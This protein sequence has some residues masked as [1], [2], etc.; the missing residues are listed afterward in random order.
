MSRTTYAEI[1]HKLVDVTAK[2]EVAYSTADKLAKTS[3]A[4]I[5][6]DVY[7]VGADALETLECNAWPLDGSKQIEPDDPATVTWGLWTNSVTSAAGAFA[8]PPAL[9]TTFASVHTS[10]GLTFFFSGDTWPSEMIITWYNG[11]T[12]LAQQ[13]YQPTGLVFYAERLVTNY[14]K[15]TIQFTGTKVPQRHLK[16]AEIDFG[17]V[18]I[19]GKTAP[20]LISAKV[21]E[22]VDLTSNELTIDTLDFSVHDEN[23]DFNMLNPGGVYVALQQNQELQ[24]TE[25][26]NGAPIAMGVYYLDTW[27]NESPTVAKFS[28]DSIMGVF[29]KVDYRT[30]PLWAGTAA[31][32]VFADIFAAA[33]FTNYTIDAALATEPVY[34][35]L[36]IVSVRAALQNVCLATR[37]TI[38][39]ARDGAVKVV[40]LPSTAAPQEIE[41]SQKLGQQKVKQTPVVNSVLVTSHAFAAGASTTLY[42]GTLTA[43]TYEVTFQTQATGIG[44]TGAT[45]VTAG[46][47]Y[48][49]V[50]VATTGTVTITGNE[51]KEYE[52]QHLYESPG[53]SATTR[54]QVKVEDCPLIAPQNAAAIAQ[55]LHE[56]Y[57]RRIVQSFKIQV[58]DEA[59]GDNLDVNTMLDARKTCIIT[60]MEIDLTGGFLADCEVRG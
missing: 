52:L 41:K 42:T 53:L 59:V 17:G 21:L 4:Q 6:D 54:S 40:R 33:G 22:E 16:I 11:A 43:G 35:C 29:D 18:V 7:T 34:G 12:Q 26:L 45:L 13:V 46:V 15:I 25:Y 60:K 19:W 23:S 32:V 1:R 47:N 50:T 31:S 58:V 55:Y 57:Q 56:D 30:G 36:D 44:V 49:K 38:I 20:K 9:Q 51:L 8:V 37:S 27:E 10:T 14:N 39:T 48:A 2:P 3:Y 24:V 28:A 5:K